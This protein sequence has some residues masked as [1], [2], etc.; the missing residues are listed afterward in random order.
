[1]HIIRYKLEHYFGLTTSIFYCI[2]FEVLSS[3]K[4]LLVTALRGLGA[5][6]VLLGILINLIGMFK[7][8]LI[9]DTKDSFVP[10]MPV[11]LSGT[12]IASIA[13]IVSRFIMDN[14]HDRKWMPVFLLASSPLGAIASILLFFVAVILFFI[15]IFYFAY[16]SKSPTPFLL[17]VMR[18]A[19]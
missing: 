19:K 6:I 15:P 7:T 9:A 13:A 18:N 12:A 17:Q 8:G 3:M 11:Y 10:Y 2:I 14:E 5:C 4:N 16:T 1:L